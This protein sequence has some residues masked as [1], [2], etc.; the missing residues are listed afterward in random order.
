M[1]WYTVPKSSKWF[2]LPAFLS[3]QESDFLYNL[4]WEIVLTWKQSQPDVVLKFGTPAISIS[5]PWLWRGDKYTSCRF[6][7]CLGDCIPQCIEM[8]S[9]L[10]FY[11]TQEK[12][13]QYR[14]VKTSKIYFKSIFWVY[15]TEIRTKKYSEV[16]FFVS[17]SGII[18]EALMQADFWEVGIQ[19]H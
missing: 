7:L 18:P 15:N 1:L 19:V 2:R 16:S 13:L 14:F 5:A 17:S 6:Y 4:W 12:D 8:L 3:C 9:T 11:C 10:P